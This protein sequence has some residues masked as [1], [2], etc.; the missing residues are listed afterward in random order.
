MLQQ[1]TGV[2]REPQYYDATDALAVAVL[3]SF[4]NE[5]CYWQ[6][7]KRDLKAGMNL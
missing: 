6:T 5:F 7:T 1:T 2:E 3:S 4:S